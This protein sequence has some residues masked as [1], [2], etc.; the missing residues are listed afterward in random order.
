MLKKRKVNEM[1]FV[2]SNNYLVGK[3]EQS[4]ERGR[5]IRRYGRQSDMMKSP[6][7]AFGCLLSSNQR[8]RLFPFPTKSA[9]LLSGSSG[10][11]EISEYQLRS[12]ARDCTN[13]RGEKPTLQELSTTWSIGYKMRKSMQSGTEQL[14]GP[15][16]SAGMGDAEQRG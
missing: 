8:E 12:Q 9:E 10:F 1:G 14:Q 7:L 3:P 15:A 2:R 4:P 5:T 11:S 13:Q 6:S 16:G